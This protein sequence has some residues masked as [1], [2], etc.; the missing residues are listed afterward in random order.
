MWTRFLLAFTIATG[1]WA[2]QDPMDLLRLVQAR[3]ADSLDRLPRYTCT[4]TIDRTLYEPDVHDRGQPL[5]T[6][7]PLDEPLT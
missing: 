7:A 6:K 2:Q 4:Q 3:I 5:A 1:V